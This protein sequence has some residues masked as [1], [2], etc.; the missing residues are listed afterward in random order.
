MLTPFDKKKVPIL[1]Y[2]SISCNATTKFVQFTVSPEMF[3]RQMNFLCQHEYTPITVT[4]FVSAVQG[5]SVL[6]EHPVVI[7][8]DDG[9]ADFFTDA[10]P[11]LKQYNFPATLYVPTAFVGDTSRWLQREGE[12]IR[13]M[14]TWDQ[15]LEISRSGIECGGHSHSHPQLDILP[16]SMAYDE[17]VRCKHILEDRLGQQVTSFAYPF[18]YYTK[19][20]QQL[21]RV[22]GYTSACA[23][24][25]AM[26]S[27]TTNPFA[28]T[29]F[30]IKAHT[31]LNTFAT[32]V[33]GHSLSAKTTLSTM[34]ARLR[35]PI[36]KVA[37]RASASLMRY[38]QKGSVS[39]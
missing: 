1:M 30:I 2:H 37:R 24:K 3:A 19:T 38:S 22:V 35:T 18:G 31:D 25:H 27:K 12:T 21:V 6:P 10:L 8:F 26:S 16:S 39:L 20:T 36:W 5:L 9:F 15:L 28:L 29:R 7:T 32:L 17:I 13:P 23:V 14:L 33:T 34:Y 11:I 4:Q